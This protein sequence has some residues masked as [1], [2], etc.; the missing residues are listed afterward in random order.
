MDNASHPP[1]TRTR[2]A[3]LGL[4]AGLALVVGAPLAA[5]AH[6]HVSPDTASAGGTRTLAFSFSHGCDGSATTALSIGIPD[7]VANATPIVEGGWTISREPGADGVPTHVVFTSD[8]P[9]EDGL[10]A[11]VSI[12]VLFAE[13]AAGTT[14]AFPVTQTCVA[15]E[16]AWSQLAEEGEDPHDLDAPAPLVMVTDAADAGDGHTSGTATADGDGDEH[17]AHDAAAADA[18][19]AASGTSADPAARWL[20]A[21]GLAAGLAALTVVLVRR[22]RS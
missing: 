7:G 19:A 11:A 9:V 18:D 22:R 2:T 17:A 3:A 10:K 14:L 20:A 8:S 4:A 21:G 6:V 15:G 1:R 13:D 16:T 12:D 5:A